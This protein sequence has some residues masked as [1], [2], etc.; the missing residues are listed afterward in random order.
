MPKS[1]FAIPGLYIYDKEVVAVAKSLKPSARGELEITDLHNHYLKQGK[2][3]V[4]VTTGAWFDVGTHD[5]LLDASVYVRDKKLHQA[6]T[7]ILS[8]AL[9]EFKVEFKRLV[10]LK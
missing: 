4:R 9:E 1:R 7:P 5:S 3:D 8:E 2:L 6:F 10:S